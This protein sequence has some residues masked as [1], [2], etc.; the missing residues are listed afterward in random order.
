MR[1]LLK[2]FA[3]AVLGFTFQVANALPVDSKKVCKDNTCENF[4]VGMYRVKNTLTMN[5]LLEKE[6]GE[7]VTIILRDSKGKMVH[8]EM[9]SKSAK[10]YGLKLNFSEV[11]DDEYTLEIAND[12]EAIVKNI[13]LTTN[14]VRETNG[15]TLVAVN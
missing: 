4:K 6:K 10:K 8:Q 5:L 2:C 9:V 7:R 1:K 11:A 13:L 15:R 12:Q 3:I 14:E